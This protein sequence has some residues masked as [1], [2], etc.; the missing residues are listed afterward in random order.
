MVS[1]VEIFRTES[2]LQ[3]MAS[4]RR[5]FEERTLQLRAKIAFHRRE[6]SRLQE[7]YFAEMRAAKQKSQL[8]RLGEMFRPVTTLNVQ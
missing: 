1:K 7:E 2:G 3:V 6:V 8:R 4:E 5:V